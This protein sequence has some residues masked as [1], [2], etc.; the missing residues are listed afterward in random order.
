MCL[1]DPHR[2]AMTSFAVAGLLSVASF[3]QKRVDGVCTGVLTFSFFHPP[4]HRCGDGGGGGDWGPDQNSSLREGRIIGNNR[5]P[6]ALFGRCY[7]RMVH[8]PII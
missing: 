1:E 3:M 4:L 8:G 6:L 2:T 7:P 5:P